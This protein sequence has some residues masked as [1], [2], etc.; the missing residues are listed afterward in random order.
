MHA[1]STLM[2]ACA[3]AGAIRTDIRPTD[4]GAAL[5]G[6]ALTSARPDQRQQAERLLTSP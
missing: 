4:I 1:L 6:I 5:E 2:G 3:S